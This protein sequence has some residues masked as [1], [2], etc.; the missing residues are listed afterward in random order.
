MQQFNPKH[1]HTAS[2]CSALQ[3]HLNVERMEPPCFTYGMNF[4]GRRGWG[5]LWALALKPHSRA[6]LGSQAGS[7]W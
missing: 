4:C 1:F 7:Q 5:M 2:Y 6:V 3:L